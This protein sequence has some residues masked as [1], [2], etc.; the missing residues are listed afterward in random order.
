LSERL[1]KEKQGNLIAQTDKSLEEKC[2]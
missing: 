2:L 1:H